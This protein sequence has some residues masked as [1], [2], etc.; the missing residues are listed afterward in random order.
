[1]WFI[2]PANLTNAKVLSRIDGPGTT[3]WELSHS[4][5]DTLNWVVGDGVLSVN[6]GFAGF[7]LNQWHH[8]VGVVD[9]SANQIRLYIDGVLRSTASIAGFGNLDGGGVTE[10]I[11]GASNSGSNPFYGLIDDVRIYNRALSPDEIK[12]LYKI[13]ATFKINVP[14][15]TGTLSDG[16]VGY[17]SF[18]GPDMA[19]NTALDRSGQGNNGTLTNGPQRIEGRIGQALEFDG[20]NGEVDFGSAPILDDMSTST[21][22]FSVSLWTRVDTIDL[23]A[24]FG[25]AYLLGKNNGSSNGWVF[26]PRSFSASAPNFLELFAS[27]STTNLR[28]MTGTNSITLGGW[29]HYAFTWTGNV[30][31]SSVHIYINGIEELSRSSDSTGGAGSYNT[32]TT[33]SLSTQNIGR[34]TDGVFDDI[35]VYNRILSPDEIKRLYKIGATFKINTSINTGTLKDGLVGYWSFDGADMSGNT[36]FDR[37]GQG[38]NGTLTN[39]PQR[40]EGR[41]GQALEFD[42][43]NGGGDYVDV[44]SASSIEPTEAI[45]VSAWV[46][47]KIVPQSDKG[48][49][50]FR[51]DADDP[52]IEA[53]TLDIDSNYMFNIN[54]RSPNNGVSITSVSVPTKEWTHVVGTYDRVSAKIYVNGVFEASTASTTA[55]SYNGARQLIIGG[56]VLGSCC[57]FNGFIDDV[58]VYNRALSPDEVK[59]LYNMGR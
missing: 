40:I 27:F 22:G 48:V 38:N 2:T 29:A 15:N 1:M 8:A 31:S 35:R 16:L 47:P 52:S 30:A 9:R 49:V 50:V 42:G 5:V 23:D 13:G 14:S 37:S 39:G 36:A 43:V 28:V 44:A 58:R 54:A 33:L 51:N 20:T 3:G 34:I 32:D 26:G 7:G 4:G 55:I 21:Q 57:M 12:R 19:G 59:R 53:Y 41:I 24:D 6:A 18:D 11:I 17:W 46:K 45:T 10:L 25:R 56:S